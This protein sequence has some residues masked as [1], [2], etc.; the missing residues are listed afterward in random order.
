MSDKSGGKQRAA[1]EAGGTGTDSAAVDSDSRI[2][3]LESR[4]NGLD[5]RLD[6]LCNAVESLG[7]RP[8]PAAASA[9]LEVKVSQ[10]P[11]VNGRELRRA[12]AREAERR[13]VVRD[14]DVAARE[15]AIA[16]PR[17]GEKQF[18]VRVVLDN[19]KSKR[20]VNPA[21]IVAGENVAYAQARYCDYFGITGVTLPSKYET[22]P[23]GSA[24]QS[25]DLQAV[26]GAAFERLAKA[27]KRVEEAAAQLDRMQRVA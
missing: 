23:V 22:F 15:I 7:S 18:V 26:E 17:E 1:S 9:P 14:R 21:M 3:A 24:G 13:S 4:L 5:D 27:Q 11:P 8:G 2:A 16:A 25:L 19:G 12:A 6:R 10:S 20:Q